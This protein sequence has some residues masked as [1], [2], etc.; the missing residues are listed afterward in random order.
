VDTLSEVLEVALVGPKKSGLI[1]KLA[2]LIPKM[3]PDKPGPSAVPH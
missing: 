2:A 3:T 1:S